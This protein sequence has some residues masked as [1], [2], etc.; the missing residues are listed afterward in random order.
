[1]ADEEKPSQTPREAIRRASRISAERDSV[2]DNP[3]LPANSERENKA[4]GAAHSG[5][6]GAVLAVSELLFLLFGLPFGDDLYHDRPITLLHWSYLALA[7]ICA[8]GGPMW[9]TIRNRWASPAVSASIAMAARDARI[10]IAVLLIFFLYGVAP[11]IYRRATAPVATACWD[12][13]QELAKALENS[14]QQ[15]AIVADQLGAAL[16]ERDRLKAQVDL[17]Q[18]ELANSV[19]NAASLQRQLDEFHRRQNSPPPTVGPSPPPV[20][21]ENTY[22]LS[23][24]DILRLR[25]E[26]FRVK[27]ALPSVIV[28]QTA[29]DSQARG[30]FVALS[31]AVGLAGIEPGGQSIGYPVTPQETGISIRIPDLERI[32]SG[33][34]AFADAIKKVTGVE[35]KYTVGPKPIGEREGGFW[36]FVGTNP[37]EN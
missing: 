1:M 19:A 22:S 18:K 3:P 14:R 21:F 25:D 2:R 33:A 30:V 24:S 5:I 23:Q 20:S 37:K 32:P 31:K 10:W 16:I 13:S 15:G 12:G 26:F 8:I 9:P 27:N 17:T 4:A 11:E 7:V 36:V 6:D 34:K 29:D 35:P 28:V